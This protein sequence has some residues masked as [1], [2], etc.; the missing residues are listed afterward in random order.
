MV[1][2]RLAAVFSALSVASGERFNEIKRMEGH[3]VLED[4]E[5]P[6]PHTYID[7]KA[8]PDAFTWGDVDGVSYLTHS[9]NQH[10]PQ[11]CGS[12][13]A[14]GALSS[15]ADRIKIAR[16][17]KGDDINLSI[18]YILNCGSEIA[19][20]CYGG[21]HTGVYEFIKKTGHV[22]FDT[23]QPYMA[24]SSDSKEGFCKHLDTTCTASNTCKTCDT[25]AG[26]GGE[27]TEIDIFPNATVAEYGM[28]EAENV[29]AIT[30]EIYARGPV[31]ATINA[32]PIVGYRGGIFTDDSHSKI[33]NHIVSI[34][35]WGY[36]E[37][38][39]TKYWIVRNSWGQYWGTNMG[40]LHIEAGKNLLGIES[41][42]A[43]ATPESW[44]EENFPC[45]EDGKN[46]NGSASQTFV[47]PST[48]VEAMQ[49]RLAREQKI[50]RNIRAE[51]I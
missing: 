36:E 49:R 3:L 34:V 32:E 16:K 1:S 15:L 33:T 12:C 50:R 13:W 39:D 10:V 17:A 2:F 18:Q 28:I 22:P 7:T 31:A 35:G 4:Y 48:D 37:E 45:D 43:W 25:F 27:C 23:C 5:K 30:A 14:H 47:D 29:D 11:Y 8:L 42:V 26:M 51:V 24:C 44:T 21:Y 46:C 40:Y 38:T 41:E 9:L 6:L 20:S 19:G